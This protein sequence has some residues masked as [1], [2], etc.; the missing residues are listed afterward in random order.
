MSASVNAPLAYD[1][2]FLKLL[3]LS[4]FERRPRGGWRFGTKTISDVVVDRL[5]ASGRA[6]RL[7][8]RIHGVRI[9]AFAGRAP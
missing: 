5:V 4:P 1:Y 2:R 9:A 6:V 7:G 3:E 8:G